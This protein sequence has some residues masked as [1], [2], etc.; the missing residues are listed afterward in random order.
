MPN[1][2]ES[3]FQKSASPSPSI[4]HAIPCLAYKDARAAIQWLVDVFGADARH[5]YDGP[6]NSVMHAEI[7]FG[8]CCVMM[9]SLKETPYPPN[10]G[11][12]TAIYLVAESAAE[13]DRLHAQAQQ[14]N[15]KIAI[16]LR[17]TDYGSHD[18]AVYDPEGNFWSFGTYAPV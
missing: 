12:E 6:D 10:N 4:T 8:N 14:H 3:V 11:G 7:W 17:D 5:V 15:A 2:T 1:P 9:G 18:F 16:T 13:V